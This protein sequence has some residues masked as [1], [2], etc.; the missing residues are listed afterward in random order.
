MEFSNVSFTQLVE[1]HTFSQVVLLSAGASDLQDRRN[2]FI[3]EGQKNA[4]KP[5]PKV[6]KKLSKPV[7]QMTPEEYR[8][9]F[10]GIPGI[11]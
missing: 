7:S 2:K 9:H 6:Q 1:T 10:S 8:A 4:K 5:K 3:E 11:A